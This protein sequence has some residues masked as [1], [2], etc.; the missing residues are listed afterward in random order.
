MAVNYQREDCLSASVRMPF[1]N[2]SPAYR[3]PIIGRLDEHD[4]AACLL[5]R[6]QIHAKFSNA[7]QLSTKSAA[8]T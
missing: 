5:D 8:G 3:Y 6:D 4:K 7:I 1:R 2:G